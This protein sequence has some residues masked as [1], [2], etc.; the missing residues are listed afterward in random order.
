M[1]LLTF[2]FKYPFICIII[3]ISRLTKHRKFYVESIEIIS[4]FC[5]LSRYG[6]CLKETNMILKRSGGSWVS[7]FVLGQAEQHCAQSIHIVSCLYSSVKLPGASLTSVEVLLTIF[8]N[9]V[10]KTNTKQSL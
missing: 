3:D 8:K 10:Q 5:S 6:S 7:Q 4:L 9:W 1:D 2:I